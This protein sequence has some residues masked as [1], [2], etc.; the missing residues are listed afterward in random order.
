MTDRYS[1]LV[2]FAHPA[3]EISRVNRRLLAAVEQ[4]EGV[5]LHD[6]Y[7][8]YPDFDVVVEEEQ[9]RLSASDII[10]L[11]FPFYWYST[12]ALLKQWQDL[13]LE[14]G[15]AYGEHG[16]AL[17]GKTLVCVMT[18]G[19]RAESYGREGYNRFTI[20]EFLR[21]LEQTARLCGMRFLAPFVLQGTLNLPEE[22]IEAHVG[23][24]AELLRAL[25]EGSLDLD[26]AARVERLDHDLPGLLLPEEK[27]S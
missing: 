6:L 4:A 19:G 18:T 27:R 26:A 15:W 1:V 9:Q 8:A 23:A 11:Q 16:T 25:H 12:P 17:Q 5:T 24:Y 2:L 3:L 22:S 13:V 10:V 7:E 14:H 20:R 21:P